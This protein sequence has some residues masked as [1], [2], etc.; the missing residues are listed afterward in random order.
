[1]RRPRLSRSAAL[2]FAL[3]L[4]SRLSGFLRSLALASRFGTS[5]EADAWVMASALPNLLF[6]AAN[7]AITVSTVP[8]V[9]D[10]R[11]DG[12]T[13]DL[14]RFLSQVWTL[15]IGAAL[16]MAICGEGLAPLIVRGLAPGFHGR[17]AAMTVTMTRIMIP[18][19]LFWTASGFLGGILQSEENFYGIALS[20]LVVNVVQIAGI[21]WLTRWLGIAGAAWGFTIAIAAQWA[22]LMPLLHRRG[23]RLRF[24]FGFDHPRLKP[25]WRMMG[26]F[27]LVSSA[28]N[29]ELITD[30]ILASTMAMGSI[31]AMNFAVTLSLV[32]LGLV[33]SPVITPIFTR[34]AIHRANG[35]R[36]AFRALAVQG[37]RWVALLVVPIAVALAVLG[38]PIIRETY[39]HGRFGHHSLWLTAHLFVFAVL[40][41]PAASLTTYLQQ[42]AYAAQNTKRPARFSL[43]AIGVNIVGNLTLTHVLGVYGL[44]LAT[45]VANWTNCVLLLGSYRLGFHVR[46]E[47]HFLATLAGAGGAM[48]LVVAGLGRLT[49]VATLSGEPVLFF[50][51]V[52]IAGLGLVT[53]ALVLF[54]QGNPEVHEL[55]RRAIRV[56]RRFAPG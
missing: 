41:L 5:M 19:I 25:L 43:I 12:D 22:L 9:T 24:V 2:V 44:L 56:A 1:M 23:L 29:I 17:E 53:Y 36:V 21:V 8:A 45:A 11:T 13:S 46:Q 28:S 48:A 27:F 15:L 52:C 3:T 4:V 55:K 37:L 26:P 31:A 32:P 14:E 39:E 6:G 40:A 18:S 30:R 49:R 7:Q 35:D 54:Q 33:I 47:A 50:A 38:T 42:L 10:A 20:P 16:A 51:I 34:L